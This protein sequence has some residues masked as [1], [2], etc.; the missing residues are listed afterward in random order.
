MATKSRSRNIGNIH[1]G[2]QELIRELSL[3]KGGR[4]EE[5]RRGEREQR[6]P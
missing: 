2:T 4:A 6:C 5:R 1:E 3:Q